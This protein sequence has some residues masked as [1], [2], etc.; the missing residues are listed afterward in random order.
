MQ[1]S[2]GEKLVK[3]LLHFLV[4]VDN[5]DFLIKI[6]KSKVLETELFLYF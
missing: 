1:K 3:M 2:F 4:V 6:V 5:F